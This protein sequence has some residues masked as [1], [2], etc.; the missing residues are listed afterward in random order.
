MEYLINAFNCQKGPLVSRYLY[1]VIFEVLNFR[2]LPKIKLSWNYFLQQ[3]HETRKL[4]KFSTLKISRYTVEGK[5]ESLMLQSSTK[6]Q[7]VQ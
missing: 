1:W 5:K 7:Y 2:V 6:L 4:Q 3:V